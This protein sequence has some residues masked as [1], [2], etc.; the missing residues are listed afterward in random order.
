MEPI[1]WIDRARGRRKV[2]YATGQ[3]RDET[4]GQVAFGENRGY[5]LIA[6]EYS[7]AYP[8][9][10]DMRSGKVVKK[11]DRLSARA[12]WVPAPSGW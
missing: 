2:I 6:A 10:V 4:M 8:T 5:M 1:T 11:V 9:V 3:S 12:V 7:G